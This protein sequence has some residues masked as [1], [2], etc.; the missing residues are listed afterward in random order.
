MPVSH[1]PL[2]WPAPASPGPQ[3]PPGSWSRLSRGG[4][5]PPAAC[6]APTKND[7][8]VWW[9]W[10][11]CRGGCGL[12]LTAAVHITSRHQPVV[13]QPGLPLRPTTP[14]RAHRS[15]SACCAWEG[16]SSSAGRISAWNC[17]HRSRRAQASSS[18]WS[19]WRH[20]A[21]RC[22]RSAARSR[23]AAS[24]PARAAVLRRLPLP[25]AMLAVLQWVCTRL[26]MAAG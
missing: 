21:C 18:A 17:V 8:W 13:T 10:A 7:P 12:V 15:A 2:R 6:K 23:R 24:E 4:P 11:N 25:L 16:P 3:L 5:P 19:A 22:C 20:T 14:Q 1:T 26:A 9:S